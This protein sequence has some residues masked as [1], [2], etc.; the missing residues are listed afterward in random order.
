MAMPAPKPDH[1]EDATD[2]LRRIEPLLISISVEQRRQAELLTRMDDRQAK[3][4]DRQARLDDRQA[5]LDDRQAKLDDRQRKQGEDIAEIKGLFKA[6][7]TKEDLAEIK[8]QLKFMP[9]TW[10]IASLMAAFFASAF[11][12][13]K[14]AKGL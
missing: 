10:T 3:L 12:L 4:D 5:R 14:F 6:V 7:A 2:I 9:S 8:G 1:P 13:V 11:V